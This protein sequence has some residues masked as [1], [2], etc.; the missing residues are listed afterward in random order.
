MVLTRSRDKER[1]GGGGGLP[2]QASAAATRRSRASALWWA[3]AAPPP[4]PARSTLLRRPPVAAAPPP[5]PAA[6]LQQPASG[7]HASAPMTRHFVS[8]TAGAPGG[9]PPYAPGYAVPRKEPEKGSQGRILR[10]CPPWTT[11]GR[12]KAAASASREQSAEVFVLPLNRLG[13]FGRGPRRSASE[14]EARD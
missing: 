1:R 10:C 5:P 2:R 12:E 8:P 11:R 6:A 4:P 7:A 3:G 13:L 9:T 14:H